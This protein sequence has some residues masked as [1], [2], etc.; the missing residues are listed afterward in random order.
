MGRMLNYGALQIKGI[1]IDDITMKN[2]REPFNFR[3]QVQEQIQNA[4]EK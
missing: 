4:T 3:R 2:V 1:G